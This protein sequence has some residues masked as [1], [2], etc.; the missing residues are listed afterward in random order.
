MHTIPLAFCPLHAS[1]VR[2]P[3][4]RLDLKAY[5]YDEDI[6]TPAE[7]DE[8]YVLCNCN[9]GCITIYLG[10]AS[11]AIYIFFAAGTAMFMSTRLTA[12]FFGKSCDK[13]EVTKSRLLTCMKIN[14]SKVRNFNT[15]L[16]SRFQAYSKQQNRFNMRTVHTSGWTSFFSATL[17]LFAF[18]QTSGR[19][20]S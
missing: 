6:S 15:R 12:F 7:T 17:T 18:H 10:F 3:Q 8:H 19:I 9:N 16:A 5:C 13:Q 20:I 11:F 4:P 14:F 2:R 1:S